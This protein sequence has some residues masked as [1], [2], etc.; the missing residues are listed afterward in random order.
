MWPHNL[1]PQ[2]QGSLLYLIIA[3]YDIHKNKG[4]NADAF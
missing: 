3:K 1:Q 2:A 4:Y